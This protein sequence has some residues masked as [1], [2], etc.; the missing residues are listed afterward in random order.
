MTSKRDLKDLHAF[1]TKRMF[2]EIKKAALEDNTTMSH[3]IRTAL[4][5]W[6]KERKELKCERHQNL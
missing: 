5:K 1:V 6:L 4:Q 3:I 2:Q